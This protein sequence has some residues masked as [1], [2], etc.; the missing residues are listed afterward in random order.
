MTDIR[1]V[2]VY[3]TE[4]DKLLNNLMNYLHNDMKVKGVT[5]F[6]A[7]SGFG[8]SGAMH[9]SA[10]LGT[11]LDLPIVVEFFDTADKVNDTLAHLKELAGE[12]HVVSWQATCE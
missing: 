9:S 7:I 2:R 4:A 12:G 3:V 6:R 10:L 1:I 8:R 5:V 11:S